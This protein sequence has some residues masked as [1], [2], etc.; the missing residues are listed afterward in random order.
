MNLKFVGA[1][2][3]L[4]LCG[5]AQSPGTFTSPT[6]NMT[7]PRA[8]HTATLLT[9]GN[10]L[11]AG[12]S[13]GSTTLASADVYDPSAGT[14][15][16]SIMATPRVNHTAT[17]LPDGRVLIAGGDAAGTAELYD[18]STGAFTFTGSMAPSTRHPLQ[19]CSITGR[20]W[21]SIPDAAL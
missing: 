20:S 7:S 11:I 16:S 4:A 17:L 18:P 2:S 15:S 8:R 5:R 13:A 3:L 12:G 19:F 10:V 21:S 1:L 9:N 14:F 6:G